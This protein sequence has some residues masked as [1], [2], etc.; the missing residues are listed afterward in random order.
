MRIHPNPALTLPR[1]LVVAAPVPTTTA[2]RRCPLEELTLRA[3]DIDLGRSVQSKSLGFRL[4]NEPLVS[5]QMRVDILNWREEDLYLLWVFGAL[6]GF[7]GHDLVVS[8]VQALS[9]CE[10][11]VALVQRAGDILDQMNESSVE[12]CCAGAKSTHRFAIGSVP[13]DTMIEDE[14]SLV[15]TPMHSIQPC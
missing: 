12:D 3:Q 9:V 2:R 11:E 7:E 4:S 13:N 1:Q 10:S 8:V 14:G 15:R 5:P 6:A